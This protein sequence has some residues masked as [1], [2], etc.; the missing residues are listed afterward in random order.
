MTLLLVAGEPRPTSFSGSVLVGLIFGQLWL[1]GGWAAAG[2]APRLARGFGLVL[3]ILAMTTAISFLNHRPPSL[4]DWGRA[5]APSCFIVAPAFIVALLFRFLMVW[6]GVDRGGRF[7]FQIKEIMAWMV[8]VAVGAG[9]LRFGDFRWLMRL[10]EEALVITVTGGA[11]GVVIV[12]WRYRHS[13][14]RLYKSVLG[15]IV[16][17]LALGLIAF[18]SAISAQEIA[19]GALGGGVY[20]AAILLAQSRDQRFSNRR[21]VENRVDDDAALLSQQD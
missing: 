2:T 3:G 18:S 13:I 20:L 21:I 11:A 6:K 4:A 14:P 5:M 12:G 19:Y 9:A 16:A 15:A 17:L 8:V 7:Q 10:D 1:I